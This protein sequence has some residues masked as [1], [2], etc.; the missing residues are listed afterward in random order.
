MAERYRRLKN[1]LHN[2]RGWLSYLGVF[3]VVFT[4]LLILQASTTF[5]DPDSFY[6]AKM[7]ILLRDHGL[8]RDF[9]WLDLTV[10]GEH[11]TDQHFL[12]HVALIPFV[13]IFP[14]LIGLKLATVTFGAILAVALTWMMRSHGVRWAA[15][16]VLLLFLVRPFVFRMSLA[17]APSTSLIFLFVGLG[18]IFHYHVRRTAM[19]AFTY[20]WWYGGFALL[21]VVVS[22]YTL[23][24]VVHNRLTIGADAA[25]RWIDKI[26]SLVGRHARRARVRRPNLAIWLA[27]V[28]GLTAGVAIHPYFPDNLVYYYHQ[29]INIG[30]I[31]FRNV[32]GVGGEWYPYSFGDLI[33]NG[34]LATLV[35]LIALLGFIVQFRAQ[36]KR[37]W[38]L[39]I[40]T[41]FFFALTLKSRRYVE[42]YIPTAVVFA[43]FSLTDTLGH[44]SGRRLLEDFKR[45]WAGQP[46]AKWLGA[47]I[48]GFAL[49]A[50]GFI[51]A[52][53]TVNVHR[54][55]RRGFS[56]TR[57][58]ESS[59]WL[60]KNTPAGSRVVHS[61]WDEFPLLFYHNSH[62]TYIVGLDPT[63]L[64]KADTERYWTWVDL[65]LGRYRGD[66]YVAVTETLDSQYVIIATGHGLMRSIIDADSRFVLR[67]A[68]SEARIYEAVGPV[69]ARP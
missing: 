28:G 41:I 23:I 8:I 51:A 26:F 53:D 57:L 6:H 65:T 69:A 27:T 61:D 29:L 3:T 1:W 45:L 68:D 11:Y 59:A 63:F 48:V 35:V 2:E 15:L 34:A 56:A 44:A 43:A 37:S 64:Y 14:P 4:Y 18:W 36:S 66:A 60:E 9:P 21:G 54:E 13:T 7:A 16:F 47:T 58:A 19:L 25:H 30:V 67:Y 17:K 40:L 55:L 33:A 32:I 50:I 5:S 46:W 10:L 12:Y 39:L 42:Y 22:L 52:R 31:N 38:T 24:S 62:N 20:V 49:F